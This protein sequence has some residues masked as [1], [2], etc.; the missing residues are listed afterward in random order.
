ML[1][2]YFTGRFL[3]NEYVAAGY[4]I[5]ER[6]Y[7][8]SLLRLIFGSWRVVADEAR[9]TREYFERLERGELDDLDEDGFGEMSRFV[10]S[11]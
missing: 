4:S 8:K 5:V 2:F 7:N 11:C 1:L 10:K 3:T 6:V 9:K